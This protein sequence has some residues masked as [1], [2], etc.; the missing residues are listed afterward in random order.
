MINLD[1]IKKLAREKISLLTKKGRMVESNEEFIARVLDDLEK[2]H[3]HSWYSEIY[4]RNKD[5]LDDIALFYRGNQITYREMFDRM[6]AY[7]RSLK[8]LGIQKGMEIP[9][10]MSNT[11]EL[12]YLL[13]AASI[14][15]AK[16]N[17]FADEF[18]LDYITEIISDCDTNVMFVEDN[19]YKKIKDY[20]PDSVNHVVVTS[21]T[22]SLPNGINPYQDLDSVHGRFKNSVSECCND[23]EKNMSLAK[24]EKLGKDYQGN[25]YEDC[26]L[27]DEFLITYTS[28][29]T[30][31]SRPKA[32]VHAVR[33]LIT[34]GR[35]HDPDVQ[36]TTSMKKFTIQ[37]HIPTHSN[38]DI[39][40]SISDALMQGS[41]LALEP[42]YDQDYFFNTLFIN[43]PNYVVATR[44]FWLRTAQQILFDPN[45]Q[46]AQLPN[47]LL[48]FAVGE[49]LE[50]NEEKLLNKALRKAK[51]GKNVIPLPISPVT[52]SV[53]GG[54]CEHGGI[55]WLLFRT[56]QSKTPG[57][58]FKDEPHGLNPFQM[59]EVAVLDQDGNH[60][61]P[62][63]YGRLVAN[64][65]CNMKKYKNNEEATKKFFIQDAQ[66]KTWGDCGV[67]GYIDEHGA[68]YMKG[69]IP[70]N[71]EEIPVFKVAD[72][73]L[74]DTKNIL[75]CEVVSI[76]DENSDKPIYVA[77][78]CMQ[79]DKFSKTAK[80][81][82]SAESRCMNDL[83]EE[84]TDRVVYRIHDDFHPPVS[85]PLT[86]CG[87]RDS[88]TLKEEGI[89]DF[90]VKPVY[91]D[92]T[93]SLQ[94]SGEYFSVDSEKKL[95]KSNAEKK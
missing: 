52:M 53:A 59:V 31:S 21:L 5:T 46:G 36:K 45:Y 48:A 88:K 6:Q 44:S 8:S 13:G 26:H 79:P 1:A 67:Y 37:A 94:P 55:F 22:D 58:I 54:D 41:K 11:P 15:G 82:L 40:S 66:G 23:N 57:Y 91:H 27:D 90:C 43:Q 63:E 51:A 14:I 70:G 34:I 39:I 87:K 7:A 24:F 62:N 50:K 9:V 84:I 72:S 19:K 81:I 89:T 92:G 47:L 73:I 78:I 69:R 33:S 64:S 35:C 38:T 68:I 83:G 61:L 49:P 17:I 29:S 25:I 86:G 2:N 30:N 10:C 95:V 74:K 18:D 77:H 65:P 16:L 93:I 76:D 28:G 75:S 71:E 32:I 56:L 42:I 60:C 12:V 85:Y 20:I 3:N 4:D 80:A